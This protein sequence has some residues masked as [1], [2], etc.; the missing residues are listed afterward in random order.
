MG[1]YNDDAFPRPVA[2]MIAAL[3]HACCERVM[4]FMYP[5]T[6]CMSQ[7]MPILGLVGL[8]SDSLVFFITFSILRTNTRILWNIVE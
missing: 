8:N 3:A 2:R 1:S 7:H 4:D 6:W 5:L